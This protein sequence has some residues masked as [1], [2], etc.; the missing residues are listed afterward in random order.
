MEYALFAV[1][2]IVIIISL[3]LTYKQ[4]T[5]NQDEY[6]LQSELLAEVRE[7]KEQVEEQSRT[8]S[9]Q[10]FQ[11]VFDSKLEQ[12]QFDKRTDTIIAGIKDELSVVEEKI[13]RLENKINY[14]L[15]NP[16]TSTTEAKQE[17]ETKAEHQAYKEIEK[18]VEEGFSLPEVA[19]KLDMGTREVKLIWKFNSRGEE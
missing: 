2:I 14:S 13:D 19:Q 5:S 18:L 3:Y 6:Y 9:D 15:S 12:Q 10:D 11:D 4:R 7:V 17:Q 16:S 8:L 1:G